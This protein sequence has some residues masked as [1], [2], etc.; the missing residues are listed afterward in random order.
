MFLA[1]PSL[2][3]RPDMLNT[4]YLLQ[5]SQAQIGRWIKP[6]QDRGMYAPTPDNQR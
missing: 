5:T 2:I 4:I 6:C 1:V 3:V